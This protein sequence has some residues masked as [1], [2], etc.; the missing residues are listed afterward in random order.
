M[1]KVIPH[2]S[3]PSPTRFTMQLGGHTL[4]LNFALRSWRK[5]SEVTGGNMA[6]LDEM[7][8]LDLIPLLIFAATTEDSQPEGFSLAWVEQAV[9]D[10]DSVSGIGEILPAYAASAGAFT[11]RTV[12]KASPPK[13]EK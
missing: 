3:A 6:T 4:K 8:P 2:K 1:S 5:L 9:E 13:A 11:M 10:F 7:D 12:P